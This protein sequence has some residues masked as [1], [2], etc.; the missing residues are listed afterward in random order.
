MLNN[1]LITVAY[2]QQT[3]YM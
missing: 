3:Y 1:A 2:W